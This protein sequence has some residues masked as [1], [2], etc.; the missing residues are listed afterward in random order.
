MNIHL[1]L[2]R[3]LAL[4]LLL[5]MCVSSGFSQHFEWVNTYMNPS[6]SSANLGIDVIV[7]ANGNAYATGYFVDTMDVDPGPGVWNLY[8]STGQLNT[9]ITKTSAQGNLLWAFCMQGQGRATPNKLSIASNGDLLLAGNF[10]FTI[11]FD[12]GSGTST[13]NSGGFASAPYLAR[14]DSDGNFLWVKTY[15][16]PTKLTFRD[17]QSDQNGN[18]YL[19]CT[20]YDDVYIQTKT[21]LEQFSSS[22]PNDNLVMKLDQQ[23][24]VLWVKQFGGLQW[25]NLHQIAVNAQGDIYCVGNFHQDTDFDPGPGVF[26]MYSSTNRFSGFV[27]KLNSNGDFVW[28]AKAQGLVTSQDTGTDNLYSITLDA[29]GNVYVTGD[30]SG[31]LEVDPGPDTAFIS[32]TDSI[33]GFVTRYNADGS[34]AWTSVIAGDGEATPEYESLPYRRAYLVGNIY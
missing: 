11:D 3:P 18:M 29:A 16:S 1:P 5:C 27:S 30:F 2:S 22:G 10:S 17:V 9:Y 26:N 13:L 28:A 20:M 21:G 31:T 24:D 4:L 25:D 15:G 14:Y 23:G 34:W 32:A 6:S 8:A 33:D 12:P 19:A 7:D